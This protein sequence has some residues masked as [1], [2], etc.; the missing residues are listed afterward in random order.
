MPATYVNIWDPIRKLLAGTP[1]ARQ[2]GYGAGR[3]SFNTRGGRCD[4]C[5]GNGVT[6]AEMSFLPDVVMTCE[7]CQGARFSP[8]TLDARW[9]GLSAA[10]LLDLDVQ[11]ALRV[12]EPVRK[13][14]RP[15]GLMDE[16]GLGYLRL[17]QPSHTLS[18]GEAQRLKLAAELG[19]SARS[20]PSLY[21]LDEPTTGLHRAD[22][23]RLVAMLQRLVDRG[24]TVVV[25]EHQ[26]DLIAASDWV[27]DLGPEGGS[28]GGRIIAEGPPAAI[29]AA[30]T[31]TGR[32]L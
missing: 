30:D 10:D 12:F 14:A 26:P 19:K 7:T 21:V 17:G 6:V 31:A 27:V 5:D 13:V 8:E 3:F 9:R 25:I 15:L 28:A 20:G 22:V 1:V 29:V 23:A 16:L 2:R 18:G 11:A 24:D 32:A 4:E